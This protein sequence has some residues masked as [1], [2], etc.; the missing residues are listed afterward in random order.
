MSNDVIK[1]PL[2]SIPQIQE[3]YEPEYVRRGIK[4]SEAPSNMS[5]GV[6]GSTKK[7]IQIHQ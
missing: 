1:N 2:R 4:V 7:E 5:A 6:L 3:P